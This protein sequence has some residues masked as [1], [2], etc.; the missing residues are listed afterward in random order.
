MAENWKYATPPRHLISLLNT[1][2]QVREA[3]YDTD[4]I[5]INSIA[6]DTFPCYIITWEAEV[7]I[8]KSQGYIKK[9]FKYKCYF[10]D[11]LPKKL[12]PRSVGSPTN[13]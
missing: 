3:V 13:G 1:M 5:V 7:W 9:F 6:N 4:E 10:N 11:V 8:D 12:I 2:V